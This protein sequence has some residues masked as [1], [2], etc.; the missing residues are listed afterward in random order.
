MTQVAA[1]ED[2]G[3]GMLEFDHRHREGFSDRG[4]GQIALTDSVIE[5]TGAQCLGE[6]GKQHA[7]LVR[8]SRMHQH[9]ELVGRVVAQDPG[10]LGERLVP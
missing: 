3:I 1:D 5:V 6:T 4:V 8:R 7:F 9:A 10:G 2:D